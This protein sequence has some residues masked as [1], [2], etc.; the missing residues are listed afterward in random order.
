GVGCH[1]RMAL[2]GGIG[3]TGIFVGLLVVH[4][5]GE[6]GGLGWLGRWVWFARVA[7][8]GVDAVGGQTLVV[9]R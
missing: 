4:L 7:G 5:L 3:A 1:L 8:G 2:V 6:L 9:L